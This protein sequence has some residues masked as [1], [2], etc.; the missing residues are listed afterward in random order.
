M[1]NDGQQTTDKLAIVD[2]GSNTIRLVIYERLPG[3]KSYERTENMKVMAR[4]RY[5][6]DS[7]GKL[8]EEG[9][10]KLIE[11][12]RAFQQTI[13]QY[14]VKR[15]EWIATASL[16]LA[17]NQRE[18]MQRVY[19]ALGVSIRLLTDEEE[20]YYGYVAVTHSMNVDRAL[21]IDI[22]GGSTEVTYTADGEMKH[23]YSFPF[24]ALSLRLQFIERDMATEKELRAM[25]DYVKKHFLSIDWLRHFEAYGENVPVISIGGSARNIGKMHQQEIHYPLDELHQYEM[26]TDELD[27]IG[28]TFQQY[29]L[30]E[31]QKHEAIDKDRADT[32]QSSLVVFR[33]LCDVI[34]T[35]RWV[36][37]SKGL[38]DG[39]L[40]EHQNDR[41][42]GT[43]DLLDES[44]DELRQRFYYG[45]EKEGELWYLA[46][47]L[48]D[49]IQ[50]LRVP[51][52]ASD[53]TLLESGCRL[54]NLGKKADAE[55]SN[56]TFF[57]IS[58]Y[59]LPGLSHK[60]RIELALIASYKN[61]R[62]FDQYVAPFRH[63]YTDERLKQLALLGALLKVSQTLNRTKQGDVRVI[64]F[65]EKR[66]T[67]WIAHIEHVGTAFPE[68]YHFDA[69]KK[70]LE[71]LLKVTL[72]SQFVEK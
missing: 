10:D 57:L 23:F 63:W 56:I 47:Q 25:R 52:L 2:I 21:T 59:T 42:E 26:T 35:T 15:S 45:P 54:F 6:F 67:E 7:L 50:R 61:R 8:S 58:Q 30:T 18:V 46:C 22:G 24:G 68:R 72:T 69:Q 65:E 4:L 29:T 9:I 37:S 14:G 33:T 64:V 34:G 36:I 39:F 17:R 48:F 40:Y 62:L 13:E 70:H 55:T 53:R 3:H 28:E 71:K 51:F 66:P 31:L 5:Y 44:I 19:D 12:L 38:R 49:E 32:L 20:A 16:R 43:V 27:A 60:E 11:T 41:Q 1:R